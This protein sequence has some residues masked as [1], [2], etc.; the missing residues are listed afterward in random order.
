MAPSTFLT[1]IEAALQ[2]GRV[3]VE[4]VRR[5]LD[6]GPH[7]VPAVLRT[8]SSE[9][10]AAQ[11][12]RVEDL[13]PGLLRLAS[14]RIELSTGYRYLFENEPGVINRIATVM[15]QERHCGRSFSIPSGA[16][17]EPRAHYARRK[18]A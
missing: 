2:D 1:R 13:L 15:E 10:R 5:F 9:P 7:A 17:T 4:V 11:I 8:H 14:E 16:T 18:R 6:W 3:T 12:Q